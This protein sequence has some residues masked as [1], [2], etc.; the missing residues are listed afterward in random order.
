MSLAKL[1]AEEE[2]G[3]KSL[4]TF[5]EGTNIGQLMPPRQV[6]LVGKEVTVEDT[7]KVTS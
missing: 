1:A 6:V 2:V 7:L 4:Q 5:L 3:L